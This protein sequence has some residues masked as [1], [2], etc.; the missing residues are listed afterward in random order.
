M[1]FFMHVLIT[2]LV[3][4]QVPGLMTLNNIGSVII[5]NKIEKRKIEAA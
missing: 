2:W 4:S 5:D 3:M 1:F